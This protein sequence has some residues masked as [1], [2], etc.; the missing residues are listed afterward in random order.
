VGG[1]QHNYPHANTVVI[2]FNQ[3]GRKERRGGQYTFI[4]ERI[5]DRCTAYQKVLE[6]GGYLSKASSS[7]A[8]SLTTNLSECVTPISTTQEPLIL[9]DCPHGILYL[10]G[11]CLKGRSNIFHAKNVQ[12]RI[13]QMS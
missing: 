4:I 11:P 13:S 1:G 10:Q 9:T 12:N 2:N 8:T 7:D 6:E 3:G 5:K